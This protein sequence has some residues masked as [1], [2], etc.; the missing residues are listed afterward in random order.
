MERYWVMVVFFN[1]VC[2]L[3]TLDRAIALYMWLP[4]NQII[5]CVYNNLQYHITKP[6]VYRSN[7]IIA[8]LSL[9]HGVHMLLWYRTTIIVVFQILTRAKFRNIYVCN[10]CSA[11][12]INIFGRSSIALRQIGLPSTDKAYDRLDETVCVCVWNQQ[13]ALNISM[14]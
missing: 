5:M 3:W 10:K 1:F 13:T 14:A 8:K 11:I 7:D 9:D 12:D 2:D 4:L 6:V